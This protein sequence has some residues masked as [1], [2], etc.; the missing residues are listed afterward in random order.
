DTTAAAAL[1]AT[2][3]RGALPPLERTDMAATPGAT[4]SAQGFGQPVP[5]PPDAALPP[6][7]LASLQEYRPGARPGPAPGGRSRDRERCAGERGTSGTR[8][9]VWSHR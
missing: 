4:V 7:C 2:R 3:Q 9:A 1:R 6:T 8:C 5:Y